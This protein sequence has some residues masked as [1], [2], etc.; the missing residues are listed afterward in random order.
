MGRHKRT[1]ITYIQRLKAQYGKLW[2]LYY[3]I[4]KNSPPE[5]YT[6]RMEVKLIENNIPYRR[7]RITVWS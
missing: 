2:R 7:D 4:N 5:G 1:E 3:R 6:S